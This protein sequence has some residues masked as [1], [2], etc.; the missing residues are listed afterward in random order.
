MRG[1]SV[2][3]RGF[4]APGARSEIDT[5]FPDFF[6]QKE[7][8]TTDMYFMISDIYMPN[9]WFITFL[10]QVN[11]CAPQVAH[12]PRALPSFPPLVRH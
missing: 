8:K 9:G 3:Y 12:G 6:P 4:P 5:S 1:K 10:Y 2:A 11:F 7:K